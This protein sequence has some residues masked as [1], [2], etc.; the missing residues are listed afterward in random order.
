M[1]EYAFRLAYISTLFVSVP[2]LALI[3]IYRWRYYQPVAYRYSLVGYLSQHISSITIPAVL[4]Y[5]LRL[6]SL[7]LLVLLIAKPQLVDI[8]SKIPVE[9][10][11]MMLV[12]DV[13]GSMNLFDDLKDQRSR[14]E[15]A[16][17]EAIAFIKKRVNDAMGVVLFAHGALARAPLTLDHTLLTSIIQEYQLGTVDSSATHLGRGI[18]LAVN[19]LRQ[20]PTTSK[21]IILLTDGDSTNEQ[22]SV[23][24][25]YQHQRKI[26][27]D[28]SVDDAID[29]AVKYGIK[30][31]A[32]A[33][34]DKEGGYWYDNWGMLRQEQD[35]VNRTLLRSIA[36]K[37]GG[38]YFEAEKPKDMETIYNKIDRLEKKEQEMPLFSTVYDIFVPW[39]WLVIAILL[40]ELLLASY[41]WV[42]L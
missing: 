25:S 31:Y 9:G 18:I 24:A 6:S 2:V 26:N 42:V 30:V 32:I 39:V 28:L 19:R 1:I 27:A 3:A 5:I 12:M 10:I 15:V 11:D 40:L 17:Q 4:L 35:S 37:T 23:R 34:G 8:R 16:K 36:D 29:L 38:H 14:F 7:A 13:S 20:S 22:A 41:A 21:V 33:V